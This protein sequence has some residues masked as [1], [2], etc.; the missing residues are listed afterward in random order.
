MFALLQTWTTVRRRRVDSRARV[1]TASLS[2]RAGVC[3][4]LLD[5]T[6]NNVSILFTYPCSHVVNNSKGAFTTP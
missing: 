6:A 2:T 5:V 3:R 1:S 4:A